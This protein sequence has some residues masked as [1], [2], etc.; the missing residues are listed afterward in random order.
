MGFTC[1]I[2][3]L[4]NAGKSTIFNAL[5]GG[6][7]QV[8]SYPFCTIEPNR[9]IVPVPDER[10]ARLGTL[11]GKKNPIPTRIEF[12]DV[13]GLVRG[14]SKGEGLGN[15]FL[16]HIRNVD[17]LVHVVRCFESAE[18]IH[19]MGAVDPARD[20]EVVNTELVLADLQV[21][22]RAREKEIHAAR[23]GEKTAQHT[24]ELLEEMLSHLDAGKPLRVI[25]EP[26]R[27]APIIREVG[28]ITSKPVLYLAN[29]GESGADAWAE[30]VKMSSAANGA[31]YVA[32]SGKIEE[33]LGQLE[34]AERAEFAKA[35]A[36]DR[37]ALDR[38]I[39]ASYAM[40]G[41]VTFYTATTDLQAW[42]VPVGT[43]AHRAA[44][45]IHGDMERG[46]IRAEVVSFAD[47]VR[48]GSEHKAREQGLL[49]AEGRDYIVRDGDIIH[50]LFS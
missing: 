22:E 38:L 25:A 11:L 39:E 13:A 41:I 9:G 48:V 27:F 4:P 15:Q 35:M 46:F 18:A 8:A 26:E 50:F 17:A 1:G 19:V 24:V 29:R 5:A 42:T 33:E 7:A 34:P 2:I 10:L 12:V 6:G 45:K 36:I 49:R 32:L 37:T 3:G 47:L 23:A 31:G 44:G 40:L 16:G 14:A 28:V 21:A 43:P 30:I 20:I